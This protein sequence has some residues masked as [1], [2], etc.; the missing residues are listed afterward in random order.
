MN[1]M[2]QRVLVV[3]TLM[4]TLAAPAGPCL[5]KSLYVISD[6]YTYNIPPVTPVKAYLINADGSLS[7]QATGQVPNIT[8][9]QGLAIDTASATLFMTVQGSGT[10]QILDAVSMAYLGSVTAPGATNLYGIVMDEKKGL[11]YTMD[12]WT[13]NL[14]VY[15]WNRAAKTLT[16]KGNLPI[17][18][19]TPPSTGG[20]LTALGIALD[21]VNNRLYAANDSCLYIYNTGDWSLADIGQPDVGVIWLTGDYGPESVALDSARQLLYTGA[22]GYNYFMQTKL[23]GNTAKTVDVT[24]KL[25]PDARIGGL[26]IDDATGDVYVTPW[27]GSYP[28]VSGDLVVYNPSLTQ[29]QRISNIGSGPAAIAIPN[30]AIK[31]R[32]NVGW[33]L[34]LLGK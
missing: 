9:S 18:L 25:L 27:D 4:L 10:L 16:P 22:T 26:G 15:T 34:L 14:Y 19:P 20:A 2:L 6:Q 23:A 1:K 30:S 3:L 32:A 24:T 11:L 5:A 7:Y 21:T 17:V 13:A 33:L 29:L 12:Y 8:N 28:G 31:N